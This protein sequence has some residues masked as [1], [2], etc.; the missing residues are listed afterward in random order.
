MK[1]KRRRE[2][3]FRKANHANLISHCQFK[4]CIMLQSNQG[5]IAVYFASLWFSFNSILFFFF[6]SLKKMKENKG[7]SERIAL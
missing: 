7:R 1:K 6:F 3:T 4:F 2:E 5:D